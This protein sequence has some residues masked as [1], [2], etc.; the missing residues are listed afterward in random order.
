MGRRE[1]CGCGAVWCRAVVVPH[2]RGRLHRSSLK[3]ASPCSSSLRSELPRPTPVA[4]ARYVEGGAS[5]FH[6]RTC[7][8]PDCIRGLSPAVP[9][10]AGVGFGPSLAY[11]FDGQNA[12]RR[13]LHALVFALECRPWC[14]ARHTADDN[15]QFNSAYGRISALPRPSVSVEDGALSCYSGKNPRTGRNR[16]TKPN[17][18]ILKR[19]TP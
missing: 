2:G 16:R 3:L 6:D 17:T 15:F 9:V 18:P 8:D 11:Q 14:R 5:C 13:R 4:H 10:S 19:Y 1:V 12:T 7:R